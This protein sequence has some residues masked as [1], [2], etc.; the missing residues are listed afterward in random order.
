MDFDYVVVPALILMIGI[1]V[2]WLSVR[3]VLSLS[4]KVSRKWRRVAERAVLSGVVVVAVAVAGR[5]SY[6][7]LTLLWFRA[8]NPPPGD[9]YTV[10]GHKMH[11]YPIFPF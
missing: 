3:R 6:N 5:A 8:H 2:I 7:A 11:I 9:I 10:D 1:L 4:T